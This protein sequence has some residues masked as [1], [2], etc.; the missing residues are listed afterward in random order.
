MEIKEIETL[1][2]NI[3]DAVINHRY[4]CYVAHM[5][6]RGVF[7]DIIKFALEKD[8]FECDQDDITAVLRLSVVMTSCAV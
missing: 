4:G 3:E 8:G 2:N 6:L 7:Y 5:K 1:I